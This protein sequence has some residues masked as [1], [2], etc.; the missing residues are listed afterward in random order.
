M[1]SIE[2][3]LIAGMLANG[4]IAAIVGTRIYPMMAPPKAEM[5]C[6]VVEKVGYATNYTTDGPAGIS[7]AM[8]N[9]TML[10]L[11]YKSG[12][13]V[14]GAVRDYLSGFKG[15]VSGIKILSALIKDEIDGYDEEVQIYSVESLVSIQY[16]D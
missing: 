2:S 14:E 7:E 10:A 6:I 16:K 13:D 3:A 4:P 9:I 11:R 15:T 8:M 12:K 5:P 1:S